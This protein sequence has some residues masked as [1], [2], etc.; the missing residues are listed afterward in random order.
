MLL[1]APDCVRAGEHAYM[2]RT[3]NVF[4]NCHATAGSPAGNPF[5]PPAPLNQPA[6]VG[7]VW[8]CSQEALLAL[9]LLG[10][11]RCAVEVVLPSRVAAEGWPCSPA[12][13]CQCAVLLTRLAEAESV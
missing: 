2:T 12:D 8:N 6:G 1:V 11:N 3:W 10:A 5:H 4:W 7:H 13:Y 9:A